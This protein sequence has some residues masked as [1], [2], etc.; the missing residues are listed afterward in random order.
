LVKDQGEYSVYLDGQ[1][2]HNEGLS[3]TTDGPYEFYGG[4]GTRMIGGVGRAFNGWIDEFRISDEALAPSQF[5]NATIPE[6]TTL[7][8]LGLG[9]LSLLI[10]KRK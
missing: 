7:G 3:P 2:L 5:L 8:L 9:L 6:P 10:R 4:P 1:L